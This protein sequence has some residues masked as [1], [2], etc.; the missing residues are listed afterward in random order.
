MA[1]FDNGYQ[2]GG[3]GDDAMPPAADSA[4]MNSED[5][6]ED[7]DT[8]AGGKDGVFLPPNF[9]GAAALKVGDMLQVKIVG[10]TPDGDIE[11]EPSAP[12]ASKT[13]SNMDKGWQDAYEKEVAGGSPPMDEGATS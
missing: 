8:E 5:G 9:P 11:I 4:G 13:D 12:M 7:Q 3:M 1:A 10:K 6:P 2:A